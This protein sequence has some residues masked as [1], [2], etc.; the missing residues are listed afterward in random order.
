MPS[1]IECAGLVFA[2]LPLFVEVAKVYSDGVET[3]VNVAVKGRWD[4]RLEDF[5]FD[6]Y[7]QLF[8]LGEIM[9]TIR[10]SIQPSRPFSSSEGHL[11]QFM[12]EWD[13]DSE[14]ERQL[15]NYFGSDDRFNAFTIISKRLLT[16]L[17]E[18]IKDRTNRISSREQNTP[19]MFGKLKELAVARELESTKSSLLERFAFFRHREKRERAVNML[20]KWVEHLRKLTEKSGTPPELE[21]NP[22]TITFKPSLA[23]ASDT[24]IPSISL[25]ELIAH[26]HPALE[27]YRSCSCA[28]KHDIKI[29]LRDTYESVDL[30]PCLAIDFLLSGSFGASPQEVIWQEGNILV[31]SQCLS[32]L[33]SK[34]ALQRLCE[35]CRSD[36][37]SYSLSLVLE[38]ISGQKRMKQ[39]DAKLRKLQFQEGCEPVTLEELLGG[40]TKLDPSEKRKLALIFAESLL[41]YHDSKWI[42]NGWAKDDICFFFRSEDEPDINH[43]FLSAQFERCPVTPDPFRN[44]SHHRNPNLLALGILLIEI[45]NE[46]PIEKW[47]TKKELDNPNAATVWMVADRVVKKM[48]RSP[49]R[50]AIEACLD[51]NWIPTGRAANLEEQDIRKGMLEYVIAPLK[52]EIR[53]LSVNQIPM[54]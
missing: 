12:T 22:N 1:G 23:D 45:F 11:T 48:D 43:P 52:Q 44:L 8:H 37:T 47:R 49:F 29:C 39:L 46:R 50:N 25:R 9:E 6:F 54:R 30:Q 20:E 10:S 21:S 18:L 15:K 42:S 32:H 53:W 28:E 2:V 35:A 33:K 31:T 51:L 41:L 4:K 24:T 7:I 34:A 14:M 36:L 17:Q 13:H 5:Y 16:L 19:S 40:P 27:A 38:D 26:L 3:I